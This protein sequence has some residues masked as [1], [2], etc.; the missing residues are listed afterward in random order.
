MA[1]Y[2][3][4]KQRAHV[5][6][7]HEAGLDLG[8]LSPADP[9]SAAGGAGD[10]PP[11]PLTAPD[12]ITCT[13]PREGWIQ[14]LQPRFLP[15]G[16]G[17][18]A[19]FTGTYK[20]EYGYSY[21]LTLP[22]N[23]HKDFRRFLKEVRLDSTDFIC[24]VERHRYRDVLHLHAVVHGAFS[25]EQLRFLKRWWSVD[26]G[27]ARVLPVLDGCVSYITKYALKHDTDSFDWRLS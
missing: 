20:D 23:V 13:S 5:V 2:R 15:S 25:A 3:N 18:C 8:V 22:R 7:L 26:R 14:W 4:E 27:H 6:A 19:Y 9:T 24:G 10:T 11:A 12:L 21:G 1:R 17:H 16:D